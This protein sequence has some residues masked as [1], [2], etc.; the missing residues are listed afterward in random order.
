MTVKTVLDGVSSTAGVP[1]NL[2]IEFVLLVAD[3]QITRL[4]SFV[5][6]NVY[7]VQHKSLT[8][9]PT[10]FTIDSCLFEVAFILLFHKKIQ[11]V[12]QL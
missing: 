9:L 2:C 11:Y 5:L 7:N 4:L 3:K 10:F 12:R 8:S 1:C 6:A